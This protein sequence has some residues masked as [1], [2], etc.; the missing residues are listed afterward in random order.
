[1]LTILAAWAG[2]SVL[3]G[4]FVG[5]LGRSGLLEDQA[6]GHL[7]TPGEAPAVMPVRREAAM[8]RHRIRQ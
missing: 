3:V 1:M 7:P 2:L 6:L 4:I 8:P 5:A